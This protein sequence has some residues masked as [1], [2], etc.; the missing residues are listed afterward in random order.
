[1]SDQRTSPG[2]LGDGGRSSPGSIFTRL[3][4]RARGSLGADQRAALRR[5]T[6]RWIGPFGSIRGAEVP[7]AIGLTFD[8]GPSGATPAV[9]DVLARHGATATFFVLVERAE[10]SKGV[11]RRIV[12][13]GH[14]VGL[15]GIDHQR[16]TTLPPS[17]V[18]RRLTDGR[19][20]LEDCVGRPVRW[21]RPPFGSQTPRTLLAAHRAGLDVVVWSCDAQDWIDEQPAHIARLATDRVQPGGVLLLHDAFE[22][23]PASPL[24]EPGFDRS[25]VLDLVL[26]GLAGR[27]LRTLDVGRLV[28][29]GRAR[30]TA[31][32]RS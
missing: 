16:L 29:E 6:D 24:P 12:S 28:E 10:L 4:D 17:E 20:R 1:M 32:F 27:D 26:T 30:R 7:D 2:S 3:A 11:L 8:D 13:E 19:R 14:E 15:H 18:R 9:L 25:E 23:D 21:F 5:A 31:W 22:S